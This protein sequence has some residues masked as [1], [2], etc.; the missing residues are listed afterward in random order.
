MNVNENLK[1]GL[2]KG[3]KHYGKRR[4]CWLPAFSPFP[5]MFSKA[6]C[7]RSV[8]SGLCGNFF[9]NKP[10]FLSVCHTSLSKTLREKEKLLITSNFSFSHSV[11]HPFGDLST[12]FINLR[13]L[14]ANSLNLEESK[15]CRLVKNYHST[16]NSEVCFLETTPI[17]SLHFWAGQ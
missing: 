15:M 2:G 13:L 10:W 9:P 16:N 3:R 1:F 5:T 6:L 14:S 17:L 7:F 11:F 12:I 8:K 4:K